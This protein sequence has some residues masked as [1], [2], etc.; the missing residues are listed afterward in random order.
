MSLSTEQ[1]IVIEQR[2]T[3]EKKSIGLAYMLWLLLGI[4]GGH[5]FYLGR[6]GSAV[7]MLAVSTLGWITLVLTDK[8]FLLVPLGVW[9]IVD[10]F[11]IPPM[12]RSDTDVRRNLLACRVA[13]FS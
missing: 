2:L 4:F 7:V 5:R 1:R 8:P 11:Q 13:R 12:I 6:N 3:S 9:L 10:I